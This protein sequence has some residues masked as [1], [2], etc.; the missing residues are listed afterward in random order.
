MRFLT[1]KPTVCGGSCCVCLSP[2]PDVRTFP[3]T[4]SSSRHLGQCLAHTRAQGWH[5]LCH[6]TLCSFYIPGFQ[7]R[8]L[9]LCL[10]LCDPVDCSQSGSSVHGTLQARIL[11]WGRHSLRQ[12]LFLTQGLNLCL[13]HCRQILYHLS[14]QGSDFPGLFLSSYGTPLQYSCLENPMDGGAW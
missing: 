10:T 9:Q 12:G 7:V 14:N 3:S 13:L 4:C 1:P 2:C 8:S 11:E 6:S 5:L